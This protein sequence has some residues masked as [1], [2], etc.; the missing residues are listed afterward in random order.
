VLV[1]TTPNWEYNAVLRGVEQG[2]SWPGPP[3]R[4]GLPLRNSD[5]RF[6]W[7]RQ[8]FADW[9]RPLAEQYGYDVRWGGLWV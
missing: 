6:E 8:E 9:C 7:T 5:H 4:D 2:A 3:G 1:A